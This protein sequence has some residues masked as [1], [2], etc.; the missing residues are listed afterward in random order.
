MIIVAEVVVRGGD[1]GNGVVN[2]RHEKYISRGGPDGG[3]GG[4]GGSLFLKASSKVVDLGLLRQ[5]K[6]FVAESGSHGGS[7]HR[8]GRKGRDLTVLVPAGTIVLVKD[9][10]GERLIADL[11]TEGEEVLLVRGGRGGL[12]NTRFATAVNQAPEIS[13]KGEPGEEQHLI[14]KLKLPTDICIIGLPNSGKSALLAAISQA[15]PRIA[16]YPFSTRDPVLGVVQS[17]RSDFVVAEM[18][19]LVEGAHLGKGLGN[20][21]L[22]HV[23]RTGVIIYLLD[24]ASSS[25]LDDLDIL[26]KELLLYNSDLLC[27]PGIV[28]VNKVDLP[29][30]QIRLLEIEQSLSRLDSPIFYISAATGYGISE[31]SA[32]AMK[33]LEELGRVKGAVSAPHIPRH[34]KGGVDEGRLPSPAIFRPKPRQAKQ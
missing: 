10:S 31:L 8:H 11:T 7:C 24:G 1:G 29:G 18:P 30:V 20:Y 15:R 34:I 28:A 12:G 2:F 14:L 33:V 22:C 17:D 16:P 5:R 25:V 3:D 32:K 27:K 21:F 13:T 23:E 9:N 19:A 4:P 6:R 26:N